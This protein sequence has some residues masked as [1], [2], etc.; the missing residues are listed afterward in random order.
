MF[1][2]Y[3]KVEGIQNFYV[4]SEN[5]TPLFTNSNTK[6]EIT[7]ACMPDMDWIYN[8]CMMKSKEYREMLENNNKSYYV[9][10]P[11]LKR[12]PDL[13]KKT[14]KLMLNTQ[15]TFINFDISVMNPVFMSCSSMYQDNCRKFYESKNIAEKFQI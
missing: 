5:H 8:D 9:V 13:K 10:H 6:E 14:K 12:D 4:N 2:P 1:N 11:V 7:K 15:E 3:K